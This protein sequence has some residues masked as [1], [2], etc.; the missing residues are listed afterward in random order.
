M[1]KIKFKIVTPEKVV[2]ED[3]IDQVTLPTQMGE[4]TVLPG[5]VPLLTALQ[6]GEMVVRTEGKDISLAIAGGFGE[7]RQNEVIVLTESAERAEAIDIKRAEEARQRAEK[8]L[9]DVKNKEN[10]DYTGLA[11]KM[12][13]E[14]ARLKVARK[15]KHGAAPTI[16][17][18]Q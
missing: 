15:R 3:E 5:H 14:L 2:Y 11:S 18:E 10:V 17:T 9:Q 8:L 6:A 1:E 7:I 16:E 12:E 4:I 13:K